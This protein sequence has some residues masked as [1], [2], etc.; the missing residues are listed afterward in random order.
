MSE[1]H[2]VVFYPVGHGDTEQIV[3]HNG[4]RVLFDFCHRAAGEDP[5]RPEIDLKK[6]LKQELE[7]AK[8]DY[9]DVVAFTHADDDHISGSTEFFWLQHAKKYQ[10]DGRVKIEELWVPAAM[11]LE[12]ADNNQQ[13]NEFVLLRQEARYRLLEGKDILVFSKPQALR[14]WLEP[15]LKERGLPANARDHL[16][17]DAGTLVPGFNLGSDKVEFFCHSPFIKHCDGVSIVRN[18]AALVFNVRFSAGSEIFDFLEVGDAEWC[19]LEDI[20]ETTRAHKNDDRLRWDLFNIP[21]HCSYKALSDEKGEKETV[22]KTKVKD[23]LLQGNEG[24]YIVSCSEP[25]PD[26]K[27]AYES[28][29]PPHIQ[30]RKCYQTHLDQIGGTAFYVTMEEPNASKPEPLV[31]EFA[32]KGIK[33]VKQAGSGSAA[34]ITSPALRAGS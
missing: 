20:V 2:Q 4:R 28:V 16:F 26:T 5:A 19:D 23:L 17:V 25:I 15:A 30:A 7:T 8:R 14:D 1:V 29:Q 21:H 24:A 9:F 22:P 34:I 10:G 13:S 27:Q 18:S 6:R 32:S 3:L 31:F 12:K 33:R 11:L